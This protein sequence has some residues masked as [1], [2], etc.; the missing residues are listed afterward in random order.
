M[1]LKGVRKSVIKERIRADRGW[2]YEQFRQD[3]CDGIA[4]NEEGVEALQMA[5]AAASS[6]K[7]TPTSWRL[8][9][10][11]TGT[12]SIRYSRSA[13]TGCRTPE[14]SWFSS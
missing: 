12:R 9:R 5:S 3:Y 10:Q 2:S 7:R 13:R 8:T 4:V 14:S 11:R 1:T 6:W